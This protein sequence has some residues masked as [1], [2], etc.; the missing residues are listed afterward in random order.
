MNTEIEE[1]C[2]VNKDDWRNWLEKNHKNKDGVWLIIYKKSYVSPN[3]NWS[4]AVDQ[5][6]CFGWIDGIKRPIDGDKYKQYFCKRK[7]NSTWS[8]INKEKIERLLKLGLVTKAGVRSI[9]IAKDNGSWSIIDS[10]ENL[11]IPD[12]LE[13]AFNNMPGSKDFFMSLSKSFRKGILQWIVLAKRPETRKK[14]IQETVQ[15]ALLNMKPKQFR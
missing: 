1:F 15:S 12:D 4:E 14:R 6:L 5:A 7:D 11:N 2:P 13:Q 3:L 10:V 8:K 9:N